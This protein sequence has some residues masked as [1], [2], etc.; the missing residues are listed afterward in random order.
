MGLF[1]AMVKVA[2]DMA[3][4][5]VDLVKD[6]VTLG[7]ISTDNGG[8]YVAEK[9]EQIKRDAEEA[10]RW[11]TGLSE[12]V[13]HD[14]AQTFVTPAAIPTAALP[15]D[16]SIF[17]PILVVDFGGSSVRAGIAGTA[18]RSFRPT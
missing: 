15:N 10:D 18:L 17:K 3:T 1:S 14:L 16:P 9:L 12:H 11:H 8:S 6:V 5:P 2:V 7:G 13:S 4:L